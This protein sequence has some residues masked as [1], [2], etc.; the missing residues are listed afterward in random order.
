MASFEDILNRKSSDIRSPQPFPVGTMHCLVDGPPEPG[1]SSQKQAL[2]LRFKFKILAPMK[3]VDAAQAAEQQI[4]G[5]SFTDDFYIENA[6]WRLKEFLVDALGI[7]GGDGTP[8]EKSLKEMLAESPGK[9]V[10]VKLRH[11]MSR[12]GK[13]VFHRVDSYARV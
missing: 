4:V 8:Q 2:L 12:D 6:D 3:D 5:K 7:D 11:E 9:Q 1:Q 13:R 10:L